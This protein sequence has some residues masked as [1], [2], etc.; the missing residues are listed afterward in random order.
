MTQTTQRLAEMKCAPCEGGVPPLTEQ[1]ARTYLEQ[2]DEAWQL[3]E[4]NLV[5]RFRFRNFR[6][7]M[8]FVNKVA[9]IAES[10]GHHPDISIS[11][12]RVRLSLFTHA[13]HGL[14]DND[15]I[16]AANIDLLIK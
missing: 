2:L 11:Y 10:E 14:S 7:A 5:R 3:E 12:N 9:E 15:F 1:Q 4:G 13:I 8:A 16:L 6:D